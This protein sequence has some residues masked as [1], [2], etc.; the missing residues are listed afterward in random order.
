MLLQL[1][2]SLN[3]CMHNNIFICN[4][5][6]ILHMI[7]RLLLSLQ[8]VFPKYSWFTRAEKTF[9][10]TRLYSVDVFKTQSLH[11]GLLGIKLKIRKKPIVLF[12]LNRQRHY[13]H[14]FGNLSANNPVSIRMVRFNASCAF[15]LRHVAFEASIFFN[16]RLTF[17]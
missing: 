15:S 9:N 17:R 10:V 2:L 7:I 6:V 12:I 4:N 3:K 13:Y 16:K 14:S 5:L 1:N 8:T 11:K